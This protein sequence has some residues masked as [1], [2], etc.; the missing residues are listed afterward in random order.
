MIVTPRR[1]GRRASVRPGVYQRSACRDVTGSRCAEV[2]LVESCSQGGAQ[3][4]RR[5]TCNAVAGSSLIHPA[6]SA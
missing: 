6:Q 2:F 1:Q 5:R 3:P 4:V